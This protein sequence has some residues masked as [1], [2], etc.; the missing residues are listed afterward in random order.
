MRNGR[1]MDRPY[2]DVQHESRADVTPMFVSDPYFDP[3]FYQ[4]A[5]NTA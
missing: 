4:A 5:A 1:D 2:H 3:L